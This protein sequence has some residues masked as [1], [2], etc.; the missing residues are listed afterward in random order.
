MR[1]TIDT[2]A[3][4]VA[5]CQETRRKPLQAARA[6]VAPPASSGW[7][8]GSRSGGR[9]GKLRA[10]ALN[11]AGVPQSWSLSCTLVASRSLTG[12]LQL[13]ICPAEG[14]GVHPLQELR[15]SSAERRATRCAK[16]VAVAALAGDRFAGT[17]VRHLWLLEAHRGTERAAGQQ[18]RA[19]RDSGSAADGAMASVV[20]FSRKSRKVRGRWAGRGL[21]A[22]EKK[23]S[24]ALRTVQ[25]LLVPSCFGC[26]LAAQ[27]SARQP[28]H[29]PHPTPLPPPPPAGDVGRRQRCQQR[30]LHL[31]HRTLCADAG[32]G[33]PCGGP[34][35][36]CGRHQ[37]RQV[38]RA[39]RGG[40]R[41]RPLAPQECGGAG[42]CGAAAAPGRDEGLL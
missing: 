36:E 37:H 8:R 41:R 30:G 33:E 4:P 32:A 1:R 20:T 24:R 6:T 13:R 27:R 21:G 26:P 18:L 42:R 10:G 17:A 29:P 25:R 40:R 5:G 22:R 11:W 34:G 12:A 7:R 39:Q 15:C 3:C 19:G 14:C 9:R 31:R 16:A 2:R 23:N 35:R 28:T 38:G